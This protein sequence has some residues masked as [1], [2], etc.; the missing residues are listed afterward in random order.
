[1]KN[2]LLLFKKICQ[3]FKHHHNRLPQHN[4]NN[5]LGKLSFLQ[6]K[7]VS[8]MNPLLICLHSSGYLRRFKR[9]NG[10][11]SCLRNLLQKEDEMTRLKMMNPLLG[12]LRDRRLTSNLHQ[13]LLLV[14]PQLL[15]VL[16]TRAPSHTQDC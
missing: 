16:S 13:L 14:K 3:S 7:S 6:W 12:K 5:N 4:L 2:Y 9:K 15:Q 8:P 10:S 11:R 1:M